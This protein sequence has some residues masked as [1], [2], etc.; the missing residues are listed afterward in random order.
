M[1]ITSLASQDASLQI[2]S[3]T[4]ITALDV[5]LARTHAVI[6]GRDILQTIR[7]NGTTCVEDTN[8]RTVASERD[9]QRSA[10]HRATLDIHDVKWSHGQFSNYIAAAATNGKVVLYDL[11]RPGIEIA[12][13]HEHHRQVHCLSISPFLGFM[14]LSGSQDATVRLWDLRDTRSEVMICHSRQKFM[15][16]SDGIRDVSWSPKDGVEFAFGTDNGVVQAW[17]YRNAKSPK[18]RINAH[19]KA[20]TAIDWHPDGTH[21]LSASQDKTVSVWDVS[22][23]IKRPK[24]LWTLRAPYPVLKAR[25]RPPCWTK[26]IRSQGAWQCTQIATSY[27]RLYPTVHVWDFRRI[28]MP[29]REILNM[30]T[31]PTDFLW[32]SQDLLWFVNREGKFHQVDVQYAHKVIDRRPLQALAVSPTGELCVFSQG[33]GIT[34]KHERDYAQENDETNKDKGSGTASEKTQL[35]RSSFD[36]SVDDNFLSSSYKGHHERRPSNRTAKSLGSTPPSIKES[37][38]IKLDETLREGKCTFTPDQVAYRMT[39]DG[40]MDS[41]VFSYLAQKYKGS[42]ALPSLTLDSIEGV[43][44]VF[45]QNAAYAQRTGLYRLAQSWRL[46]GSAMQS[47]LLQNEREKGSSRQRDLQRKVFEALNIALGPTATLKTEL[48]NV[49]EIDRLRD[50][51]W[52]GQKLDESSSNVPTPLAKPYGDSPSSTGLGSGTLPD[53]DEEGQLALPAS[54]SP[55]APLQYLPPAPH[56]ESSNSQ[57]LEQARSRFEE[58]QWYTSVEALQERRAGLSSWRAPPKSPLHFDTPSSRTTAAINIP[59]PLDRH[60]SDESF[61]MFS[62]SSESQRASSVPASFKSSRSMSISMRGI[63]ENDDMSIHA[64]NIGNENPTNLTTSFESMDSNTPSTYLT[65][66]S[67]VFSSVHEL[68]FTLPLFWLL[69]RA[70]TIY[71]QTCSSVHLM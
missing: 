18:V 7:V 63:P 26:D 70:L 36:D 44:P 57:T 64:R 48:A 2:S 25:W 23:S 45:E 54:L 66:S 41:L 29:F 3:G 10:R 56:Q 71:S 46:F 67:E 58:P 32:H 53:P 59:P 14:L 42:N 43:E 11:N 65:G 24:P 27:E 39:L 61:A 16:Q 22:T 49:P 8:L 20:C 47:E 28:H 52:G 12:R 31:A 15:G 4:E 1:R 13:L 50:L 40:T 33:R 68:L 69:I 55:Q 30:D 6:A 60:N 37:G 38:V 19:E 9:R 34:R 5:N 51:Q 35:S 21:L 62:A 17:D